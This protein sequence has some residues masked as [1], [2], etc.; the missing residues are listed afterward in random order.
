MAIH[1][2]N[3]IFLIIEYPIKDRIVIVI[4]VFRVIFLYNKTK[5]ITVI[6]INSNSFEF[7]II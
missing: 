6:I 5:V 1:M 3:P 7:F 2:D 4:I